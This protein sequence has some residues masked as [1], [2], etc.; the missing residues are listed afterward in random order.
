MVTDGTAAKDSGAD[1]LPRVTIVQRVLPHY[2]TTFFDALHDELAQNGVGLEVIYGQHAPDTVP[3]SVSLQRPWAK[4]VTN[5]YLSGLGVSVVW[6]P[7]L[8]ETRGAHL[9]IVEH[10]ARLLVNYPLLVRKARGRQMLAYWGHGGNCQAANRDGYVERFK[11]H[12]INGADW[13]FGYTA[14][15]T[16]TVAR[17]GFPR[18]RITTVQNAIDDSEFRAGLQAVDPTE[19]QEEKRRLGIS[20]R[21]TVL[22]CGG[23]YPDKRLAFLLSAC[24][25]LRERVPDVEV[26]FVGAGPDQGLVEQACADQSWMHYVGPVFGAKRAIYFSMSQALL[27]PGAVGLAVTDSFVA[28]T[29]LF[30]TDISTHGPEIDYLRHGVNGVM[31]PPAV[32]AYA[33]SVAHY[34]T[35]PE[36]LEGLRQGCR[37]SAEV[38]TLNNMVRNFSTGIEACLAA[39]RR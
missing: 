16:E 2:R 9:V 36:A 10:A 19:V 35:H 32:D 30:T 26:V 5:R 18:E 12:L 14:S 8:R 6:Q 29:P 11:R 28:E 17:A 4:R 34:L 7:V 23:M 31:T 24:R 20:G 21:H 3:Q 1:S 25:C 27:M 13:W 22:Y 15:S 33:E 38:Y 39:G 37:E